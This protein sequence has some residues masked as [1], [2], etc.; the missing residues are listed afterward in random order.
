MGRNVE[1]PGT[2]GMTMRLAMSNLAWPA[3]QEA[4]AF[5]L[6]AQLG[7][8]GVEVAPTRLAPWDALPERLLTDYRAR[9]EAQGLVASSLQAILFGRTDLQL[10]GEGA[11]FNGLLDH[12]RHVAAIA[13]TLGAGVLVFGSPRNRLVGA[14]SPDTA[15]PLARDRFRQLGEITW[16][17]GVV[18]GIEPVPA[19]YGG[20]FLTGWRD[21]LKMVQDVNHPG[22]RVHLD[23]GCVA[24]GG[25]A[26]GEAIR[27]ASA[28]L[29]HFH[30]AQPQLADFAAPAPNHAEAADAL[31]AVN[32]GRW[33]SIEMREPPTSPLHSVRAAA[34]FVSATYDVKR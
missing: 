5:V 16:A 11:A 25:D 32:Y 7:V 23:T 4:A 10:L 19:V 28:W 3:D 17:A 20:D 12:M 14:I 18:I 1:F 8:Q 24:L 13:A 26:I 29:A 15:W 2:P 9:L 22:V 34:E 31:K 6:L 33:L 30:A 21:V 27:E